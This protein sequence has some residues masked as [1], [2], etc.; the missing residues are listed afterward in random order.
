MSAYFIAQQLVRVGVGE[1]SELVPM[2]VKTI[3]NAPNSEGK[4]DAEGNVPDF[5][6]I[7]PIIRLYIGNANWG[8][9]AL[10]PTH[11]ELDG[12]AEADKPKVWTVT[13]NP[14]NGN[15]NWHF[16]LG[17]GKRIDVCPRT[18][19]RKEEKLKPES[20]SASVMARKLGERIGAPLATQIVAMMSAE[21][22]SLNA[23][24][25]ESKAKRA[26]K[27]ESKPKGRRKAA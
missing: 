18:G 24:I 27:G 10:M 4:A 19:E 16:G 12:M 6:R 20:G 5:I 26:A 13:L 1:A 9:P 23:R 21:M 3:G 2:D 15:F 11:E 14:R 7:P 17:Y 8:S 22:V 25:E